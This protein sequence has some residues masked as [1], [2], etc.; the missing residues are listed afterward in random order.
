M[1]STDVQMWRFAC[2][3]T[4]AMGAVADMAYRQS[5]AATRLPPVPPNQPDLRDRTVLLYSRPDG[6]FSF[7]DSQLELLRD[8]YGRSLRIEICAPAAAERRCGVWV[9]PAQPTFLLLRRKEIVSVAIGR[10]TTGELESIVKRA[11]D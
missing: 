9:S 11:L 4:T 5:S 3:Q 2:V 10:L 6:D 7:Q 1:L 8:E